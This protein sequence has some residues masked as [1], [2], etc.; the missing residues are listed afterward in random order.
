MPSGETM[1][2]VQGAPF[3][4]EA[5]ERQRLM[6]KEAERRTGIPLLIASVGLGL[7]QLV[8]IR[9]ADAHLEKG[10]RLALE[11]G[12]FLGYVALVCLLL[13]HRVQTVGAVRPRCP[14]CGVVL[15]DISERVAAATGR[16]DACGGQVIA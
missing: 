9:W 3:T 2:G 5:F 1:P 7:G 12:I 15:K 16:C 6:V 14:H 4:R 10:L 13:W 11:G 8:F